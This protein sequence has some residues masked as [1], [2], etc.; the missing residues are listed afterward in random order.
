MGSCGTCGADMAPEAKVCA[1]CGAPAAPNPP[2]VPPPLAPPPLAPPPVPPLSPEAE[3]ERRLELFVGAKYPVYAAKWRRMAQKGRAISWNWAAMMLFV[4]WLGYRGLYRIAFIFIAVDAAEFAVESAFDT[5]AYASGL[6]SLAIGLVA[7]LNAN[8]WYRQ[9][10]EQTIGAI[11]ASAPPA[12]VDAEI[13]RQ[14]APSWKAGLGLF[15]L[16]ALALIVVAVVPELVA[17]LR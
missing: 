4:G 15:A 10:A 7:T 11:A 5:P 2:P 12:A 3:S 8:R 13:A 6:F 16:W 14:G 1:V 9:H 17:L